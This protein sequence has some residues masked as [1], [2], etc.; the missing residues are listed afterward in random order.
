MKKGLLLSVSVPP[1]TMFYHMRFFKPKQEE[2][3]VSDCNSSSL[4]QTEDNFGKFCFIVPVTFLTRTHMQM[5]M[6]QIIYCV[7]CLG[8]LLLHLFISI[9]LIKEP[10]NFGIY[11][12]SWHNYFRSFLPWLCISKDSLNTQQCSSFY[13]F[14]SKLRRPVNTISILWKN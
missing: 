8:S 9:P 1:H 2:T 14:F 5:C 4:K 11:L 7:A 6:Q 10:P 13:C 12:S 3:K